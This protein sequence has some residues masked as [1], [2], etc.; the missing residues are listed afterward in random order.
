MNPAGEVNDPERIALLDAYLRAA[1]DAI[2]QGV[3]LLGL[4]IWC[5]QDNFAGPF[6]YSQKFGLV[7]TDFVTQQMT[8]KQS[9]YWYRDVISR[10]GLTWSPE[11]VR[12]LE[13]LECLNL[14][15]PGILSWAAD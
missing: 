12:P 4:S 8:P 13:W 6:G 11:R 15:E 10:N 1:S 5:F 7:W 3:D 9:A 2:A 14:F